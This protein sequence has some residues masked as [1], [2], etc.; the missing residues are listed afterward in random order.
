MFWNVSK[1]KKKGWWQLPYTS[2]WKNV[3]L[4]PKK[5]GPSSKLPTG[6]LWNLL[7]ILFFF[8]YEYLDFTLHPI[9]QFICF[10]VKATFFISDFKGGLTRLTDATF[11]LCLAKL[12]CTRKRCRGR[13]NLFY[14]LKKGCF[15]GG[16]IA[17]LHG[18]HPWMLRINSNFISWPLCNF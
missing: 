13:N 11:S 9:V 10:N 6:G 12:V 8:P 2:P 7:W 14:P 4:S 17:M 18:V 3:T 1:L 16:Y 5:V 15:V